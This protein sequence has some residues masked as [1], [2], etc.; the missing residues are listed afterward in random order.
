M[1][2]D[3]RAE[4]TLQRDYLRCA[5]EMVEQ[6]LG[7]SKSALQTA[8]PDIVDAPAEYPSKREYLRRAV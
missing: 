3:L 2:D 4:L 1:T 8:T 5:L 6:R 7:H